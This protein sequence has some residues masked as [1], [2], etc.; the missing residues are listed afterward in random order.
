MK[1]DNVIV[2]KSL[3][4]AVVIVRLY[5]YLFD[6]KKRMLLQNNAKYVT[7]LDI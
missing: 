1:C 5:K 6:E 7:N 3:S 4:F 2:D